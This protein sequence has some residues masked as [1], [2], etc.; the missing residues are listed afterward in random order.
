MVNMND[1]IILASASPRRRELLSLITTDFEVITADVDE[2]T[3]ENETAENTVMLLSSKKAK[4]VSSLY[5]GRTVIGA[6]TV[7]VCDGKILGKPASRENAKEM[8]RMLSGR[9][10]QV[11]T[12]VTITNGEKSETF[13][14]SSDVAF[15]DLTDEEISA[16]A[17]RKRLISSKVVL[18]NVGEGDNFS[19]S[20]VV[21]IT[22]DLVVGVVG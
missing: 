13:Y 3:D 18:K 10:H 6:D 12:G 11:L 22:N 14:V 1:K 4:A 16:Y 17:E 9:T 15:F 2:T 19:P 21:S 7:V 20:W 8:L 5:K